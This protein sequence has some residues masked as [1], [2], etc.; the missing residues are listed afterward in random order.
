MT[1]VKGFLNPPLIEKR[2]VD[3][4]NVSE[5]LDKSEDV[6]EQVETKTKPL[7]EKLSDIDAETAKLTNAIKV[8]KNLKKL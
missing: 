7:E 6:L 5:L 2:E 1:L 8:A 4:L 3:D